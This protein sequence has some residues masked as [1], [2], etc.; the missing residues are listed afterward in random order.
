MKIWLQQMELVGVVHHGLDCLKMGSLVREMMNALMDPHLVGTFATTTDHHN[1]RNGCQ[2][3]QPFL[4]TGMSN[5]RPREFDHQGAHDKS[6]GFFYPAWHR[7]QRGRQLLGQ[8]AA[9][10]GHIGTTAALATHLAGHKVHQL[11]GFDAPYQVSSNPS[12]Q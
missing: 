1:P 6:E 10:L 3:F 12:N 7:S 4:T 9:G 5:D 2:C 11:A 8:G